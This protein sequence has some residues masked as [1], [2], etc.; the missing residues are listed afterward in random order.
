MFTRDGLHICAPLSKVPGEGVELVTDDS[1]SDLLPYDSLG[2]D[3]LCRE[4]AVEAEFASPRLTL[5]AEATGSGGP[6]CPASPHPDTPPLV[7]LTVQKGQI[8]V[9]NLKLDIGST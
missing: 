8:K 5:I 1:G 4:G 6:Y 3:I 9:V 2:Q 7:I